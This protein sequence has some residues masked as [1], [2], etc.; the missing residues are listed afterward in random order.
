MKGYKVGRLPKLLFTPF[1]MPEPTRINALEYFL[2]GDAGD[3]VLD[4]RE[5][6]EISG[7]DSNLSASRKAISNGARG[8]V[9][10]ALLGS[11]AL[12]ESIRGDDRGGED[13]TFDPA[14]FNNPFFDI[15]TALSS[16]LPCI[17]REYDDAF[18]LGIGDSFGDRLGEGRGNS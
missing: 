14:G 17:L 7:D 2:E 10:S 16:L 11:G 3:V 5:A 1:K 6:L 13:R 15:P 18:G 9:S 12:C 8:M 4:E